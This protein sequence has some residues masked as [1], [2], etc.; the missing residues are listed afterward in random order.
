MPSK[1]VTK[2][3]IEE[4][5]AEH[6][7]TLRA[8]SGRDDVVT[9][10]CPECQFEK[11]KG[12]RPVHAPGCSKSRDAHN[13]RHRVASL[14]RS[15]RLYK[16]RCMEYEADRDNAQM[17]VDALERRVAETLATVRDWAGNESAATAAAW[18]F[19][20]R[21]AVLEACVAGV[22]AT[23]ADYARGYEADAG[24]PA[25]HPETAEELR[26]VSK[27]FVK[28]GEDTRV[29]SRGTGGT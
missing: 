29:A 10:V 6:S 21:V 7:E 16:D 11:V 1:R 3:Q 15:V 23:A 22:L 27:R 12:R 28:L 8:L 26:R 14:M 9:G 18:K 20:E 25:L 2:K 24:N 13:Q 4:I 5:V 19:R 17:Q